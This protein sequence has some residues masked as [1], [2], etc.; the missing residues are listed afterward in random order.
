MSWEAL[1]WAGRQRTRASSTQIVLYVLANAADPQ[2]IAMGWWTGEEHWWKY[3]MD[4]TRL[5]RGTLFKVM[6]ELEKLGALALEWRHPE[7]GGKRRAIV[8][9]NYGCAIDQRAEVEKDSTSETISDAPSIA[10]NESTSET[11]IESTTETQETQKVHEDD[12][13]ESTSETG[14]NPY[15]DSKSPTPTPPKGGVL[16]EAGEKRW[17]KFRSTYPD[18]IVDLDRARTAYAV[19]SDADQI[20]ANAGLHVYIDRNRKRREKSQ[21]AH[22]YLKKR[23]WEGLSPAPAEAGTQHF[24]DGSPEAKAVMVAYALVG[25][26]SYFHAA[27]KSAQG[28]IWYR[29]PVDERLRALAAAPVRD[30]WVELD[31]RQAKSWDEA[32]DPYVALQ[33]RNH[34]RQGSLAPWPWPPSTEGKIYTQDSTGPPDRVDGTLCT[35]DDMDVAARG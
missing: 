7:G 28:G 4:R 21:K 20:A 26:L 2:G 5:A 14:K 11:Q 27:V 18:G 31:Y 30:E 19:L 17:L 35:G 24:P 33:T 22:L 8:R 1:E 12:S 25:K 13:I 29:G 32:I 34:L 23:T 6:G 9:L 3:L 15:K 10:E 16:S